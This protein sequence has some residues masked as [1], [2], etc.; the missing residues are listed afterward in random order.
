M[1]EP[2]CP[3]F[4]GRIPEYF[5][6]QKRKKR[7]KP[8]DNRDLLPNDQQG[9]EPGL[10][11]TP[12]I[13]EIGRDENTVDAFGC[14]KELTMDFHY[15]SFKDFVATY[16]FITVFEGVYFLVNAV[17]LR[18]KGAVVQ[19]SIDGKS[20]GKAWMWIV[21][22]LVKTIDTLFGW[23]W[24]PFFGGRGRL[25]EILFCWTSTDKLDTELL[26]EDRYSELCAAMMLECSNFSSLTNIDSNN[27]AH[28]EIPSFPIV[29]NVLKRGKECL[30][31]HEAVFTARVQLAPL[32]EDPGRQDGVHT[33][34]RFLDAHLNGEVVP[35][36]RDVF[37]LLFTRFSSSGHVELHARSNWG[38]TPFAQ[39][40][41]IRW[42][43][44]ATIAYNNDGFQQ[45]SRI[46]MDLSSIGLIDEVAQEVTCMRHFAPSEEDR[47]GIQRVFIH[48]LNPTT[49]PIEKAIGRYFD[50]AK[51]LEKF[52][53][54]GRFATRLWPQFERILDDVKSGSTQSDPFA[55]DPELMAALQ[56]QLQGQRHNIEMSTERIRAK[57]SRVDALSLYFGTVLHSL[58]HQNV[59]DIV[60][61]PFWLRKSDKQWSYLEE[62]GRVVRVGFLGDHTSVFPTLFKSV[63]E[64]DCGGFFQRVY[65]VARGIDTRLADRMET[66]IIR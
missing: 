57:L 42:F 14:R 20:A 34:S 44:K 60:E 48:A 38:L 59:F 25:G 22:Y 43:S 28:F 46:M 16:I 24:A 7:T 63:P 3:A 29:R 62:L 6:L 17:W 58:D 39:D 26:D 13:Y 9:L 2:E 55:P 27:I 19:H 65:K 53:R 52:S 54:L 1:V 10:H 21:Y 5:E 11:I 35:S 64:S 47:L 37:I 32:G 31:F 56:A 15:L 45:F 8:L 49:V 4:W 40:E 18:V 41:W 61:N 12:G 51:K 30:T 50:S 33:Q 36:M 66:C 23:I